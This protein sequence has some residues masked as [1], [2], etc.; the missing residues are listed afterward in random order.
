L[1]ESISM[2]SAVVPIL[3]LALLLA[4]AAVR[5]QGAKPATLPSAS[6]PKEEVDQQV[7]SIIEGD[8][9][10]GLVVGVIDSTGTH[11]YSYGKVAKSAAQAPDGDTIFEIGSVTKLFTATVVAQMLEKDEIKLNQAADAFL[12][13]MKIPSD[14]GNKIWLIHLVAHTSGL[15]L[16]PPNLNSPHPDNPYSGYTQRQFEAFLTP[17]VLARP[18]GER[19]EYSHVG[20]A[21]LG[22]ALARKEKKSYEQVIID[23]IGTPLGLTDTR[24]NLPD[25]V[26]SRLAHAYDVDGNEVD[27]WDCPPMDG[28]FG[29]KSTANDLLKFC[30][31]HL[32]LTKVPFADALKSMQSRQ[33]DVNRENDMGM[34]WQIG[35][36]YNVLWQNGETGGQHV[37]LACLPKQ[38]AAVVILANSS[39][40]FVDTLGTNLARILGGEQLLPM[41]M[42]IPKTLDAAT[43]D[44]YVGEY[45]LAPKLTLTVTHENNTLYIQA[46]AQSKLKLY[47]EDDKTFFG[48]AVAC[49]VEFSREGGKIAGL[50]FSQEGRQHP[51]PKIK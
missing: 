35:R 47:A 45:A 41:L 14:L 2:K 11:V 25:S 28:A 51:A 30:S 49:M 5:A 34:A 29:L 43:L 31:A 16:N 37:F 12:P 48:K 46:S 9:S 1:I 36:K 20:Y 26:R 39:F 38:K 10:P 50:T 42:K 19:Y 44:E 22:Q 32:G 15:P 13:G 6:L 33:I 8:Y 27:F 7:K 18:P 40:R 23:R 21:L 4:P 24:V 3:M 17:Y